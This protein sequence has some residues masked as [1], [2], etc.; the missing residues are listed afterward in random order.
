MAQPAPP[1]WLEAVS[2]PA[3][4]QI[5]HRIVTL[6]PPKP[7]LGVAIRTFSK[8]YGVELDEAAKNVSEFDSFQ[9]FFTRTLRPG[10]R[11]IAMAPDRMPSPADGMFSAFG[12]L[13]EGRLVQ[14]KGVEY[15]LD[16]LL[17]DSAEADPYRLG[18]YAVVYLAPNNYH[19]VHCPWQGKLTHW[20]YVPGALYPVNSIGLRHVPGL[21]ARNERIIGHFDSE[22]GRVAM[23]M[24]G[25]TFVGHMSVAFADVRSNVGQP[26]S[27]NVPTAPPMPFERGD[28]FGVFEM[29][30]T[31]VMVFDRADME[32][33]MVLGSAVRVGESMLRIGDGRIA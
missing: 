32:P 21:F 12:P 10:A 33:D 5:M 30:S 29:G 27:G 26:G 20:R 25:A 28:E 9:A 17:G 7:V 3:V 22:F 8:I 18:S 4:S 16:A 6:R 15:A 31:V 14:A 1:R 24:V 13:H 23:I 19:R 11:P 2:R